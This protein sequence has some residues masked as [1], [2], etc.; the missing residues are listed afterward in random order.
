MR[1]PALV[2]RVLCID[3]WLFPLD[4]AVV[5]NETECRLRPEQDLLFID[6]DMSFMR[7]SR[8]S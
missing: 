4:K 7:E 1:H 2:R 3:A 6:A 5:C 8:G